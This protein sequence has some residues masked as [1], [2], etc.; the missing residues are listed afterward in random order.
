MTSRG[1]LGTPYKHKG[2]RL[3]GTDCIGFLFLLFSTVRAVP[4]TSLDYGR[5][6]HN[7]KLRAGL[8]DY[9]GQPAAAHATAGTS[10]P[11]AGRATRTTW[12]RSFRI[13][14]ASSA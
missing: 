14:S 13:R 9:L 2:C 5:T 10:S 3:N 8:I 7:G 12:A 11:C 4:K 1:M 6:P